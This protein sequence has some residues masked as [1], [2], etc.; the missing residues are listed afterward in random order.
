MFSVRNLEGDNSDLSSILYEGN[1]MSMA[2]IKRAK[3][4]ALSWEL[5]AVPNVHGCFTVEAG[6]TDPC[7][8]ITFYA[9]RLPQ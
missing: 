8:R 4:S 1:F 7:I 5:R 2:D 6:P 3:N 9:H